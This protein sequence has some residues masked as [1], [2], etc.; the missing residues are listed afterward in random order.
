MFAELRF[1]GNVSAVTFP[2]NEAH[3][4]YLK[5]KHGMNLDKQV[6]HCARALN[7]ATKYS[8]LSGFTDNY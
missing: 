1:Y 4:A 5:T 7:C 2:V 3:H 6:F 8:L